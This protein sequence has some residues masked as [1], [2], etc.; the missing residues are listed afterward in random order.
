MQGKAGPIVIGGVGGSGTRVI[1]QILMNHGAYMGKLVSSEMVLPKFS[2]KPYTGISL[3]WLP[4]LGL[5]RQNPHLAFSENH[6]IPKMTK[7]RF[8]EL[9]SFLEKEAGGAQWGFKHPRNLLF[10]GILAQ[11]L[12]NMRFIHVIR[13]GR[14]MAY[15]KNNNQVRRYCQ[16]DWKED[17][18]PI[19]MAKFWVKAN[20]YGEKMAEQYPHM[21][22]LQV[23]YDDLIKNPGKVCGLLGDFLQA[24]IRPRGLV[25]DP[26]SIGRYLGKPHSIEVQEI[27]NG[28]RPKRI[29]RREPVSS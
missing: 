8:T 28:Y 27:V 2:Y 15:S 14:D 18:L 1:T 12:P 3:D 17:P 24:D 7:K 25:K 5:F 13:D 20:L 16:D 29:Q 26:G 22:Y 21:P 4:I 10:L 19:R 6:E 11:S 9:V 23:S